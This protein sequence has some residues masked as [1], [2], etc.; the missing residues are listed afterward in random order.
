M[1][2]TLQALTL[3]VIS[4]GFALTFGLK[5]E[6]GEFASG[7]RKAAEEGG[8]VAYANQLDDHANA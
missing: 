2:A 5:T 3:A 7:L 4:L 1:D 6:A 8:S